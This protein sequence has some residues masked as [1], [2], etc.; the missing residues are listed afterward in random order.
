MKRTHSKAIA[1]GR[2][3]SYSTETAQ[4]QVI[5]M[6]ASPAIHKDHSKSNCGSPGAETAGVP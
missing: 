5:T 4:R 6:N 3:S 2:D 1:K